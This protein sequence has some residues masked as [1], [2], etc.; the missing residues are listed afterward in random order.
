MYPNT[1]TSQQTVVDS[2]IRADALADVVS[3]RHDFLEALSQQ[4]LTK[5]C[6]VDATRTSRSTVDRAI[7]ALQEEGLVA[8]DGGEYRLTFTGRYALAEF[9]AYRSRLH[10]LERA[11][12]VLGILPPDADLDPAA[13]EGA[14]V[15]ESPHYPNDIAFQDVIELVRHGGLMRAVGPALPPRHIDDVADCVREDGLE[16]EFVITPTVVDMIDSAPC[17]ELRALANHDAVSL[18]L[19]EERVPYALWIVEST[20]G[21]DSGLVVYTDT[22]V[23]GMVRNDTEAMTEWARDAFREYRDRAEKRASLPEA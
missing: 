16:L 19:L 15:R 2:M 14:T 18:S 11:H 9:V 10:A 23:K 20:D 3:Q 13:L 21:T 1:Y 7:D 17:D 4:S 12:D 6:L 8:R 22:G 5:P